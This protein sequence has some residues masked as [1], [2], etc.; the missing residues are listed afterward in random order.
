L[1]PEP[2]AYAYASLL[3]TDLQQVWQDVALGALLRHF[4][5]A[6][7]FSAPQQPDSMSAAPPRAIITTMDLMC[8]YM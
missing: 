2:E 3:V 1:Q 6:A 8:A 7:L 4:A 5:L